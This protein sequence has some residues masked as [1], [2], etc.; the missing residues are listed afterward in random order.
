MTKKD[1]ELIARVIAKTYADEDRVIGKSAINEV[2]LNLAW[3]L[4]KENVRFN[5]MRFMQACIPEK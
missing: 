3:H 4:E 5:I 1:Y 2:A